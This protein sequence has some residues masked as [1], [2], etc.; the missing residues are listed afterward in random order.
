MANKRPKVSI[1]FAFHNCDR[2]IEESLSSIGYLN[3]N[4]FEI[5]AVNDGSVDN[6]LKYAL[7]FI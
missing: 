2:F 3:S 1:I 4:D 6:S 5:I 7:T